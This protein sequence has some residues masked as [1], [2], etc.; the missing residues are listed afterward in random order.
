MHR[1]LLIFMIV[2]A[3]LRGWAGEVMALQMAAQQL[4]AAVSKPVANSP[5]LA[6]YQHGGAK[7]AALHGDCMG[8]SYVEAAATAATVAA[9]ESHDVHA[10]TQCPTCSA[11]QSCSLSALA[12]QMR[13]PSVI[14]FS[15]AVPTL[16]G[17]TFTSAEPAPGLKPPIS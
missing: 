5:A 11:C 12:A 16:G 9:E 8:R 13:I 6:A 4:A 10:A 7:S 1:L 15:H 2:L 17:A 14:Q 3:P